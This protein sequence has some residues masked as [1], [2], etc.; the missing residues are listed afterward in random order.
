[1]INME[2]GAYDQLVAT[3]GVH[4]IQIELAKTV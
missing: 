4:I 1:M 2:D 3:N